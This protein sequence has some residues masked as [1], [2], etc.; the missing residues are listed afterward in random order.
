MNNIQVTTLLST[1][2][3]VLSAPPLSDSSLKLSKAYVMVVPT[4]VSKSLGS[5]LKDEASAKRYSTESIIGCVIATRIT[6]AMRIVDGNELEISN[7]PESN[8]V[9][10]DIGS[11]E[12]NVYCECVYNDFLIQITLIYILCSP[13]PIPAT[14]GIPRLFVAPSHRRQGVARALLDAAAKTAILGCPLNP[15]SGQIA[16]SQPTASGHAVMKN[17]GGQ[18]IR[19]YEEQ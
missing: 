6:S 15:N 8:L 9:R 11:S 4:K 13:N 19:I 5:K 12:G 2:D 18:S 16:F 14:L 17:W 1:I 10:V 3:K 7:T